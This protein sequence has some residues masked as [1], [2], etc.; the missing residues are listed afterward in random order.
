[1]LLASLLPT[2]VAT[3]DD[4][5]TAGAANEANTKHHIIEPLLGALGWNLN[6][7]TEVDREFKVFDGTFLDYALRID[8]KPKLFI[9]AKALGKKLSDKQFIAQIVNYANNEGVVWCVLT[10][11]LAYQVYKSNEPVPMD[12]KL[13]FEVDLGEAEGDQ[14]Q[15]IDALQV[16][17]KAS[18]EAGR[19]DTWGESVFVDIRTRAA[20]AKLGKEPDDRF[21]SAVSDAVEGPAIESR[22]LRASLARVLG[23]LAGEKVGALVGTPPAQPQVAKLDKGGSPPE[24]PKLKTA[25]TIE[26]HTAKKPS[27]I[28]DLFEQVD[29]YAMSLGDDVQRRPVKLYI[30]YYAGKRSFFTLELQKAKVYAYISLPP[31]EAKPWSDDEMRDVSNIG[32][33]GMGDTEF[34]LRSAEQI[35]KLKS[36]LQESYLRNRK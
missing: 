16:L 24:S 2:L 21:I 11:G 12:R 22:R 25:W 5:K 17:G 10:N 26:H 4:L 34:V 14:S 6:D 13:L 8:G 20:L 15:Q 27:A 29:A 33:F 9:E 7:F 32:H 28:V 3:A 35:P 23:G 1:M 30:G 36:L 18:V 31:A 19:L